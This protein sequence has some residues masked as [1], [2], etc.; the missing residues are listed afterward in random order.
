MTALDVIVQPTTYTVSILPADSVY[1]ST[2]AITVERRGPNGWAATRR[3]W[4][5]GA[6]GEWDFEPL[7]SEHTDDWLKAHWFSLDRAIELAKAAAPHVCVNH[8][9]AAQV[10][11]AL[12]EAQ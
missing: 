6:D 2:Y 11:A 5:L 4:C 1:Y 7:P 8:T 9:T 12:G 10:L 3:G